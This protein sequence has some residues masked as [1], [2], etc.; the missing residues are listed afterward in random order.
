[1]ISIPETIKDFNLEYLKN[2]TIDIPEQ[3][4]FQL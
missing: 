2:S 4:G 3:Y 1:M